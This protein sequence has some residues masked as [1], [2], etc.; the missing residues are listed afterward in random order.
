MI[1]IKTNCELK[2]TLHL[3]ACGLLL[4]AQHIFADLSYLGPFTTIKQISL[5]WGSRMQPSRDKL[6]DAFLTVLAHEKEHL[7]APQWLRHGGF[8]EGSNISFGRETTVRSEPLML[9]KKHFTLAP[10]KVKGVVRVFMGSHM[11]KSA[12]KQGHERYINICIHELPFFTW[13]HLYFILSWTNIH[14]AE[15]LSNYG[16]KIYMNTVQIHQ[17]KWFDNDVIISRATN[18]YVFFVSKSKT[19]RSTV[20]QVCVFVFHKSFL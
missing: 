13:N 4:V 12:L 6:P 7:I 18:V 17:K 19:E 14:I 15:L 16:S 3:N 9:E 8:F 10:L 20:K 2:K 11:L 1:A 5:F